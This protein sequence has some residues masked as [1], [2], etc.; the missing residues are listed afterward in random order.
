MS[1]S[2]EQVSRV[3]SCTESASSYIN[4][5]KKAHLQG[6]FNE[7][8]GHF[9]KAL[10]ECEQ[11]KNFSLLL[12]V[13]EQIGDTFFSQ[14]KYTLATKAYVCCLKLAENENTNN[15]YIK[16]LKKTEQIFL[17]SL[18][19]S[20]EPE[21]LSIDQKLKLQNI[22]IERLPSSC[23]QQMSQ[24]RDKLSKSYCCGSLARNHQLQAFYK[25]LNIWNNFQNLS[26]DK[27]ETSLNEIQYDMDCI[28]NLDISSPLHILR[29]RQYLIDSRKNISTLLNDQKPIV[30][31]TDYT[32]DIF[33]TLFQNIIR[34]SLDHLKQ[35]PCLFTIIG[36]GSMARSEMSPYSDLEY[37][38]LVEVHTPETRKFFITLAKLIEIKIIQLGETAFP[39]LKKGNESP[40]L[41]GFRMDIGG[42]TPLSEILSLIATPE[43]LAFYQNPQYFVEPYLTTVNAL[44]DS[45]IVYGSSLLY[46]DYQSEVAKILSTPSTTL[47]PRTVR[48]IQHGVPGLSGPM[49]TIIP[50]HCFIQDPNRPTVLQ[51]DDKSEMISLNHEPRMEYLIDQIYQNG[52][53]IIQP[54]E[55]LSI[56]QNYGRILG[57]AAV[58]EFDPD[59]DTKVLYK[60][61]YVVIKRELYRLLSQFMSALRLHFK[62][63]KI[64]FWQIC[65]ELE[66]LERVSKENIDLFVSI[67]DDIFRLRFEAQLFYQEEREVFYIQPTQYLGE[68]DKKL[69]ANTEQLQ[70]I[71]NIY[72]FIYPLHSILSLFTYNRIDSRTLK[73]KVLFQPFDFSNEGKVCLI[74]R[75]VKKAVKAFKKELALNLNAITLA[76]LRECE[77]IVKS[78]KKNAQSIKSK[79][80]FYQKRCPNLDKELTPKLNE[81]NEFLKKHPFG[82]DVLEALQHPF[83]YIAALIDSFIERKKM[84]TIPYLFFLMEHL[85]NKLPDELKNNWSN[86][87]LCLFIDFVQKRES[88][89]LMIDEPSLATFPY[90]K[91]LLS[92]N[93]PN[94]ELNSL[95]TM[96]E[97]LRMI[98]LQAVTYLPKFMEA[99]S[100]YKHLDD[101]ISIGIPIDNL[102]QQNDVIRTLALQAPARFHMAYTYGL[103][104]TLRARSQPSQLVTILVN[105]S[106]QQLSDIFGEKLPKKFALELFLNLGKIYLEKKCFA[107]AEEAL[108]QAQTRR[109]ENESDL[110]DIYIELGRLYKNSKSLKT[111]HEYYQSEG[112][113]LPMVHSNE[114]SH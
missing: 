44:R 76:L 65:K 11:E 47:L 82:A 28:P 14:A 10:Q 110:L 50:S 59:L 92:K 56:G 77:A 111:A 108:K 70:R 3:V 69:F 95:I 79:I 26:S 9:T 16:K 62:I 67:M 85:G 22:E 71:K 72:R 90:F 107:E 52:S 113:I 1:N 13:V 15:S 19:V 23:Q 6:H 43:T 84:E 25:T 2:V 34:E 94:Q 27:L 99:F 53:M 5:G 37:A 30:E 24:I 42:N 33:K 46:K 66:K 7:A 38:I 88:Y 97:E 36:I 60:H 104:M 74:K 61:E 17:G 35:A 45:C 112:D 81:L 4:D 105:Q 86:Q 8:I 48:M 73:A 12:Y 93:E 49:E 98:H 54:E 75:E 80:P 32:T 18:D 31:I 83:S 89:D 114:D 101:I 109:G 51:I 103:I 96:L 40:V 39:L 87:Y 100:S 63:D 21:G 68:D 20:Q 29:H 58:K 64:N 41:D 106:V 91:K 55:Q 57:K 102:Q 78:E